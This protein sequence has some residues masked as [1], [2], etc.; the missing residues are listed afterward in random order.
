[1]LCFQSEQAEST[2][3]GLARGGKEDAALLRDR[4]TGA[5]I[6][7]AHAMAGNEDLLNAHTHQLIREALHATDEDAGFDADAIR[8]LTNRVAAEKARI[9]PDCMTC[10]VRC[11]R[12]DDYDMNRLWQAEEGVRSVKMRILREIRS[13]AAL[14]CLDDKAEDFFFKALHL[15][16]D[17]WDREGLLPIALE[18]QAMN[19]RYMARPDEAGAETSNLP[20]RG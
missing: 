14:S 16:G 18:A 2:G 3:G 1:M 7:L 13:M 12:T 9:V 15:L 10:Q 5:L 4:L 17:D 6:G 20:A 11:G 19:S 8:A